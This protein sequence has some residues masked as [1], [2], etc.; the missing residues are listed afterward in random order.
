[1]MKIGLILTLIFTG[2]L[3]KSIPSHR[4]FTEENVQDVVNMVFCACDEGEHDGSLSLDE[5]TSEV[6]GV[7]NDHLFEYQP[8]QEDFEE[9]DGDNDGQLSTD[10]V[11]GA[12]SEML[13]PSVRKSSLKIFS[14]NVLIEAGVRVVG[15]ACD[16][17]ESMSLSWEEVSTKECMFVQNWVFG[18]NLDEEAFN[19]IDA[20][21]DGNEFAQALEDYYNVN[22]RSE[23]GSFFE[24]S[25]FEGSSFEGSSFEGSSFEEALEDLLFFNTRSEGSED[26]SEDGSSFEGSFFEGSSFE[27][28][29]FD[30]STL[31]EARED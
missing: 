24:G 25:F 23:E 26:G 10:E 7:V 27:D 21:G 19:E 16:N 18:E 5:F 11:F 2:S 6:C 3:A 15:C 31:E 12:L 13:T 8:N 4:E 1:M 28:S 20:N 14:N 29:F 22:T 9:L 30:G 17:D